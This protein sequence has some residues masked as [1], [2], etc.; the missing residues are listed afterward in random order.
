[1]YSKSNMNKD[2]VLESC[3]FYK[4]NGQKKVLCTSLNNM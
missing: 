3:S 2:R 4:C 1:V